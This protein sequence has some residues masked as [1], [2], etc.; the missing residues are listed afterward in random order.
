MDFL[1][2]QPPAYI[3]DANVYSRAR[4]SALVNKMYLLP[5]KEYDDPAR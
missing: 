3:L 5:I 1:P 4:T 2:P